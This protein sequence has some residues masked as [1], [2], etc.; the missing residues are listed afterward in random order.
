MRG[1]THIFAKSAARNLRRD[2]T[3]AERKL[4]T[5]LRGEQLDVKFRRQHPFGNYIL[6]FVCLDRKLVVE[7]DGSQHMD[8]IACD[9]ERSQKLR[10]AGFTVLRFWNNEVLNETEAVVQTIWDALNPSLPQPSP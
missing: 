8:E 2:M 5:C 10:D 4:W 3:G 1:Q 9:E 7:V 6:D